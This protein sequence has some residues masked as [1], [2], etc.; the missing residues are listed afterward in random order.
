MNLVM[1]VLNTGL[2]SQGPKAWSIYEYMLPGVIWPR[3]SDAPPCNASSSKLV[4]TPWP[5][6]SK[7]TSSDLLAVRIETPSPICAF[8]PPDILGEPNEPEWQQS[9]I[10]TRFFDLDSFASNP[11]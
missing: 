6:I 2:W 5:F 11:K 1:F 3:K 10:I 7:E 4:N 8:L 9:K